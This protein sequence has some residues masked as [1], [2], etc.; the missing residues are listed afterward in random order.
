M[1]KSSG[2]RRRVRVM[3]LYAHDLQ[4]IPDVRLQPGDSIEALEPSRSG[5]LRDIYPV[6]LSESQ[7]RLAQQQKCF[8]GWSHGRAAHFSWVQDTGVHEIRG[9]WRRDAVQPGDFWIYSCRTA[10]WARGRRLYP[11]ALASILRHYKSLDYQRALIYVAEEN[12]SSINGIERAGF[13][14]A[15]RIRSFALRTSLF[16]LPGGSYRSR[17]GRSSWPEYT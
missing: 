1:Q 4:S 13:V 5:I 7:S 6:D 8:I 17:K 14:F 10:D 12:G 9:T 11:A 3:R 2:W 16:P 15:E